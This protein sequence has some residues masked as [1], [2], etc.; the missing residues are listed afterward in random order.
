METLETLIARKGTIEGVLSTIDVWLIVFG[1]FVAIGVVG[2]SIV[3]YLAWRNNRQL[4]AVQRSI[5]DLRQSD[6]ANAKERAATAERRAA[7]LQ[8]KIMPRDLTE[9]QQ[10]DIGAACTRFSGR[11]VQVTAD[12]PDP[13]SWLLAELI[14]E[15]L[16]RYGGVDSVYPSS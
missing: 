5:D 6:I 4:H 15:A 14:Q 16:K 8:A 1:I 3:G 7:E 2:E 13:E 11:S 10:K 12:S 9:E